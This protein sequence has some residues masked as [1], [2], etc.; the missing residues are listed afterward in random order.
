LLERFGT[1]GTPTDQIRT[2]LDRA[3]RLAAALNGSPAQRAKV[4]RDLTEKVI[5]EQQ[6]ITIRIRRSS[7]SGGATVPPSSENPNNSPIEITA[8]VAFKRVGG[9]GTERHAC[10]DA[11]DRDRCRSR[12]SALLWVPRKQRPGPRASMQETAAWLAIWDEEV[13][14]EVA[15]RD[16]LESQVRRRLAGG[17]S[18][19]RTL[20]PPRN[21][22]AIQD[23]GYQR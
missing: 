15:R 3:T 19:I 11:G 1:A 10:E 17:G 2:M 8:A 20:G 13:G 5:V 23:V 6:T 18:R 4:V 12:I 9:L 21:G 7:L 14:R 16:P 22:T